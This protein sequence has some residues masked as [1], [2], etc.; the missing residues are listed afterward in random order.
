MVVE[1]RSIKDKLDRAVL[2]GDSGQVNVP[3]A[4]LASLQVKEYQALVVRA[5]LKRVSCEAMNMAQE[6]R[7][8]E[9]RHA[10]DRHIANVTS[11]NYKR[12][13]L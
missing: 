3:K 5:R 13:H 9:L 11:P 1:Q 4:E 7:A 2:V 12:S 8:E 6:L 10:I